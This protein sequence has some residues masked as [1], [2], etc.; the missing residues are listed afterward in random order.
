MEEKNDTSLKVFIILGW[1]FSVIALFVALIIFGILG[2]V[3]GALVIAKGRT[4]H[5]IIIIVAAI[6]F[7]II[8]TVV[9][10]MIL[11]SASSFIYF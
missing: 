9:S 8:S 2:I 3:F 1:V 10:T 11:N 7:S 5:G 4:K 6:I